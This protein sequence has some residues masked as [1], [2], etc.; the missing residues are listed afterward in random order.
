M[1]GEHHLPLVLTSIIVA[2]LASY[3]ALDLSGRVAATRGIGRRLWLFGGSVAM[4]VGIWSMHFIA[5]LSFHLPVPI[6]YDIPIWLASVA[7][8]IVASLLALS[9]A[10]SA[11][12]TVRSL[13]AA[14]PLMGI[15][16]AGMHYTGMAAMRVPAEIL[17]DTTLVVASVVIAVVAS[18]VAL[19]LALHF[20]DALG[21]S[22]AMGKAVSAVL[23]GFAICGMHYTGML[24][25]SF[26]PTANAPVV[27]GQ[28]LLATRGLAFALALGTLLI[29]GLTLAG[30]RLD[31]RIRHSIASS[32][33][34]ANALLRAEIDERLQV[35]E[36]LRE[37]NESY[38]SVF[39]SLTEFVFILDLEGRF[40]DV[41]DAVE[42]AYGYTRAE[43]IGRPL[44]LA[45]AH[46]GERLYSAAAGKT[47]HM[48]S[49]ALCK[50]GRT[51]PIDLV[52][53]SA[54]YFGENVIL[55]TAR[56]IT[57]R[58]NAE[59]ELASAEAHYRRLVESSPYGIFT[60][61]LD[62]FVVQ[63]NPAAEIIFSP[64]QV[65]G[66][67]FIELLDSRDSVAFNEALSELRDSS[68]S[69]CDLE[70]RVRRDPGDSRL[71]AVTLTEVRKENVAPA[72][73]GIARDIT[74][75]RQQEEQLR[76][77]ERLAGVG[78][79][80][81]GVA[82]ELNNPLTAI[83][84]FAELMLLDERAGEDREALETMQREA[85]R[86][87]RIVSDL[88]LVARSTQDEASKVRDLVDLN[89]VIRHVI[90]LRGYVM[91]TNNI[92]VVDELAVD[93][94]RVMGDRGQLEQVFLN[95]VVNAGQAMES[96]PTRSLLV[97]TRA[98]GGDVLV[99]VGDTGTGIS[100]GDMDRLFDPFWTTKAPGDG[101]GLGLSLVH[102][103][104]TDHAGIIKVYSRPGQGTTF[105]LT[106]PQA[107]SQVSA[108]PEVS[109]VQRDPVRPLRLLLVEDEPGIRLV[110]QHYLRRR[111]HRAVVAAD[112]AEAL[113][114]I[115]AK[116]PDSYDVIVS[117][118]R[119]PGLS[120]DRFLEKLQARGDGLHNRLMFIS[121]DGANPQTARMM[122]EAAVPIMY[123][124]FGLED[125][126]KLVETL[127]EKPPRPV[128]SHFKPVTESAEQT[129]TLAG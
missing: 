47:Q 7:I 120:G 81:G 110:L 69:S 116:G 51:F 74:A 103:I 91:A 119:M 46:V 28:E 60:C 77:A 118:L 107:T 6:R 8:A 99:E 64:A 94:P 83:Q 16:I 78:T 33:E 17:Y 115:S 2:I 53:S 68:R 38:R 104:V 32:A 84:S 95:L 5:M 117:D 101:T 24:A 80:I 127:A 20:R 19:L 29:L 37:S 124:P 30:A 49:T 23:M 55:A 34:N 11:T 41:N 3:S 96:S 73:H 98:I 21:R 70:L 12:A 4:G 76:R 67:R 121:G 36:R 1:A 44:A 112:G 66:R 129:V 56:D 100:A 31:R 123:K 25:A 79:L 65:T 125:F 113:D 111:G 114:L 106:F 13:L 10:S 35:Q 52:L 82:H 128:G 102:S 109:K 40:L 89:D 15:A 14:A 48:E 85:S 57:D 59:L 39:D 90:K 61:D 86:A 126:S 92:E 97:R 93:L 45:N 22:A 9:V 88:R 108:R 75:E 54:I 58:K 122:E 26:H 18:F 71:L 43:M 63:L 87:A 62:G 27:T 72:I 105:N 42:R 50:D